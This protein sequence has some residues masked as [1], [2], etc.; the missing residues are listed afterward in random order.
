MVMSDS[1]VLDSGLPPSGA[2]GEP[3]NTEVMRRMKV[4]LPQPESAARPITTGLASAFT[5]RAERAAPARVARV[6]TL[7]PAKEPAEVI[8]IA[9]EA[10]VLGWGSTN[11][12]DRQ[13]TLEFGEEPCFMN[14]LQMPS[15]ESKRQL[16]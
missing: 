6:C 14:D 12:L 1:R 3:P 4:D 5:T 16:P 11:F 10:I 15:R 8:A 7:A 9:E 13:I 2:E